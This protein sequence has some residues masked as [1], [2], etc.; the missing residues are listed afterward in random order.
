VAAELARSEAV[1]ATSAADLR[2]LRA[3]LSGV[4]SR[5]PDPDDDPLGPALVHGDL[6]RG[7]LVPGRS[8]PVL[9]DLELAGWGAASADVAPQIVAVRRYGA[10]PAE[11]E[12]FLEAY[13]GDPRGWEGLEVLVEAYELWVTAW[14]VGNRTTSPRAEREA[15]IRMQR[16][17]AGDSPVWSLR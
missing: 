11:L 15:D 10:D 9:A 13:G 2:L 7:N 8:G 14:A 3:V 4:V 17:R 12:V 1:G 6:H 16:W 5:W